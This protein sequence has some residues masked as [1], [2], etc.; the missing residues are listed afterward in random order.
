M[1][2]EPLQL[3]PMI[4]LHCPC[5]NCS[6]HR[7]S[8][9]TIYHYRDPTVRAVRLAVQTTQCCGESRVAC[10][11]QKWRKYLGLC[12]EWRC[13]TTHSWSLRPAGFHRL[14]F[15]IL[16]VKKIKSKQNIQSG[17]LIDSSCGM[18]LPLK[19]NTSKE[20]KSGFKYLSVSNFE[21]QGSSGKKCFSTSHQYSELSRHNPINHSN[22]S[23]KFA[24]HAG[25]ITICFNKA[26]VVEICDFLLAC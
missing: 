3:G 21:G 22:K 2:Y 26:N 5:R 18:L 15:K 8:Y 24:S 20:V 16:L 11:L 12:R 25:R 23:F 17:I 10:L 4:S 7:D 9:E 19:V 1:K 6:Y 13:P 14:K